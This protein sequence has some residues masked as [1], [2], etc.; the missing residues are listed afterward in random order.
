VSGPGTSSYIQYSVVQARLST[1][2]LTNLSPTPRSVAER[3]LVFVREGSVF[4][5]LECA[6]LTDCDLRIVKSSRLGSSRDA[7]VIARKTEVQATGGGHR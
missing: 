6:V 7:R 4:A 3:L 1:T 5:V 2:C